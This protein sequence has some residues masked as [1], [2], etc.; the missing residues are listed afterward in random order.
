MR[1]RAAAAAAIA[2]GNLVDARLHATAAG[3]EIWVAIATQAADAA[4]STSDCATC[5]SASSSGRVL[6]LV[7][8]VTVRA[9]RQLRIVTHPARHA[10]HRPALVQ[11][12]RAGRMPQRARRRLRRTGRRRRERGEAD[13]V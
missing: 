7:D 1:S 10:D 12:A 2:F 3:D 9:Q 6:E 5:S 11:Q 13:D 8:H 4:S